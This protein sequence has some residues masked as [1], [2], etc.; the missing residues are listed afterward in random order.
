MWGR[1]SRSRKVFDGLTLLGRRRLDHLT[2]D[3]KRGSGN[4]QQD[5]R[6]TGERNGRNYP[7]ERL[8]DPYVA[9]P[10]RGTDKRP[11]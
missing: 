10:Q 2:P 1:H 6:G 4:P 3:A 8:F 5:E 9:Q 7:R 11:D